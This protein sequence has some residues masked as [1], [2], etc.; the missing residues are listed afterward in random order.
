MIFISQV[1]DIGSFSAPISLS[2]SL[3]VIYGA[4]FNGVGTGLGPDNNFAQVSLLDGSDPT[5]ATNKLTAIQ[6]PTCAPTGLDIT[7]NLGTLIVNDVTSIL[8]D[9]VSVKYVK[10]SL[11][12]DNATGN[13]EVVVFEKT[14]LE[15]GDVP[16]GKT[17][18]CNLKEFSV[19]ALGTSLTEINN[20]IK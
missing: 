10:V 7:V 1:K 12:S 17:L 15:Y 6:K 8:A 18:C 5:I 13:I 9:P 14:I 2:E 16:A 19:P 4:Q 3:R 20:W 11:V